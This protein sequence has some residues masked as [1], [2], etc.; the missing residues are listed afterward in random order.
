[1][2]QLANPQFL[3]DPGGPGGLYGGP[4]GIAL[5]AGASVTVPFAVG[6]AGKTTAGYPSNCLMARLQALLFAGSAVAAT[7]GLQWQILSC[8]DGGTRYDAS[9]YATGPTIPAVASTVSPASI[10]LPPGQYKAVLTN[11]DATNAVAVAL[12]LGWL[13]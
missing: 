5:A 10:D 11:L 13:A 1:M 8:S 4:T 12:S 7:N 6:A 3:P 9:A 2:S